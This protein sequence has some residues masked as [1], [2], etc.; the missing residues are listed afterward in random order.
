MGI[1]NYRVSPKLLLIIIAPELKYVS[2]DA[3]DLVKKMLTY[4]SEA[5]IS[6]EEALNH[7]WILKKGSEE[8]DNEIALSALKNLQNFRVE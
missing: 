7:P 8:Y 3:I 1:L 5:R 2:R 6:A 4:N